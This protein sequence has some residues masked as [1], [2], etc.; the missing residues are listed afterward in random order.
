MRPERPRAGHDRPRR[1]R[2]ANGD[3]L[4]QRPPASVARRRAGGRHL[5]RARDRRGRE[6]LRRVDRRDGSQ[7]LLHG[8]DEPGEHVDEAD[9][10][11]RRPGGDERLRLGA[12]RRLRLARPRVARN[13]RARESQR[14]PELGG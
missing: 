2:A 6:R 3:R 10:R 14:V 12:C 11:Q 8:L 5:P 7:R 1:T 13:E 4:P 9:S